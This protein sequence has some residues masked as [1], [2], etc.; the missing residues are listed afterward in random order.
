MSWS[1]LSLGLAL[2]TG[3]L[4]VALAVVV[5]VV[6]IWFCLDCNRGGF[7]VHNYTDRPIEI[8]CA[9]ADGDRKIYTGLDPGKSILLSS[10]GV[11]P[12]E[13]TAEGLVARDSSGVEVARHTDP[14]CNHEKWVIGTPP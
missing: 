9:D 14:I 7:E 11:G 6:P 3:L 12:T 13:C 4:A 1:R 10:C 8:Y 2:A 5:V